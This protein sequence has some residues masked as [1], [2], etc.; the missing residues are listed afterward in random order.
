MHGSDSFMTKKLRAE[1]IKF[2]QCRGPEGVGKGHSKRGLIFGIFQAHEYGVVFSL[3]LNVFLSRE[4]LCAR[5]SEKWSD[6][7]TTKEANH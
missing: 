4:Q 5:R 6:Y 2:R 7:R 1:T 3:F